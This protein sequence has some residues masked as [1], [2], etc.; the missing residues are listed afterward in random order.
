VADAIRKLLGREF[1]EA[2]VR[3][4]DLAWPGQLS[5]EGY[6]LALAVHGPD[7]QRVRE[8]ARTFAERLRESGRV[9]DVDC[10]SGSG[11]VPGLYVDINRDRAAAAGVTPEEISRALADFGGMYVNDFNSFVRTWQ[12]TVAPVFRR[13][14]KDL[15]NLFVR[16]ARGQLVPLDVV[17][18]VREVN[19]PEVVRRFNSA[20]METVTANLGPGLSPAAARA[21]CDHL[22]AEVLPAGYRLDWLRELPDTAD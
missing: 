1:P 15:Q 4:G 14:P 11:H 8:L 20:P 3:V 2:L 9:T 22:A 16:N 12:V 19:V 18:S 7:E 17:A 10:G 13:F 6:A 21:L 5:P